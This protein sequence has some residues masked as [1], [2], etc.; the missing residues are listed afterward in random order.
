MAPKKC[1]VTLEAVRKALQGFKRQ[2]Y[3]VDPDN[4]QHVQ[5][6]MDM[7]KK[8]SRVGPDTFMKYLETGEENQ[9]AGTSTNIAYW[10][11]PK[12]TFPTGLPKKLQHA[13]VDEDTLKEDGA[14]VEFDSE[15]FMLVD[16]C[17]PREALGKGVWS[18]SAY[19]KSEGRFTTSQ[20]SK[21]LKNSATGGRKALP[22]AED[23]DEDDAQTQLA[24]RPRRALQDAPSPADAYYKNDDANMESDS[25]KQARLIKETLLT[26]KNNIDTA[27]AAGIWASKNKL[28][29]NSVL[30]WAEET[31][32]ALEEMKI[33]ASINKQQTESIA[34][35]FVSYFVELV[36]DSEAYP[37]WVNFNGLLPRLI[38]ICGSSIPNRSVDEAKL[39][40]SLANT[41]P[42]PEEAV[43]VDVTGASILVRAHFYNTRIYRSYVVHL[44]HKALERA[45]NAKSNEERIK[46]LHPWA[47]SKD[48]PEP[49]QQNI[50][51]ALCM[52][53]PGMP[54]SE[55][56]LYMVTHEL[57]DMALH[58]D[59]RGHMGVAA[60]FCMDA[61]DLAKAS[62]SYDL[63]EEVAVAFNEIAE[64][65]DK[66]LNPLIKN[67]VALVDAFS[68]PQFKRIL[69]HCV[70]ARLHLKTSEDVAEPDVEHIQAIKIED[71]TFVN[72][73]VTAFFKKSP[74][75]PPWVMGLHEEH[76]KYK[77]DKA[78]KDAEEKAK[79]DAAKAAEAAKE[80]ETQAATAAQHAAAVAAG[81]A[82]DTQADNEATGAVDDDPTDP[83]DPEVGATVVVTFGRGDKNPYNNKKAQVTKVLAKDCWVKMLEGPEQGTD[84]KFKTASLKVAAQPATQ[85]VQEVAGAEDGDATAAEEEGETQ[86]AWGLAADVFG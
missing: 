17:V 57:F 15:T 69:M 64:L 44:V 5:Q 77:A 83:V 2:N 20:P 34:V 38:G 29:N 68:E 81:T 78:A 62:I 47:N 70:H 11:V 13:Q 7:R 67:A 48:I 27:K 23:I 58:W 37:D 73:K 79:A 55:R 19:H 54:L 76:R 56:I 80:A 59:A 9:K 39:L 35:R 1:E 42:D 21:M 22:P 50:E 40:N 33:D 85:A 30:F 14:T 61:P 4:S 74:D 60:M 36:Q 65:T 82:P 18:V 51:H 25:A 24:T 84:K 31:I 10:A 45:Q 3:A 28:S 16:Q 12:K 6:Y 66:I 26:L 32:G 75:L 52:F 63:F 53:A 71:L 43:P 41:N 86:A 8:W 72:Q 49:V 46:V